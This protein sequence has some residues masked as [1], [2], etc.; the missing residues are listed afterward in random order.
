MWGV[1]QVR[2]VQFIS[3]HL[4]QAGH[5]I[6]ERPGVY[7]NKRMQAREAFLASGKVKF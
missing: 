4:D 6:P 3:M 2:P 5:D 7:T 1:V